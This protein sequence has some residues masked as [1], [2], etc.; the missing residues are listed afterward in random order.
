MFI[1]NNNVSVESIL[2]ALNELYSKYKYMESNFEKSKSV[3]KSKIPSVEQTLEIIKMLKQKQENDE[4]MTA[5]YSLCDTIYAK[6]KVQ[7]I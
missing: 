6:A 2:G 4:E 3:Y 5:N 1:E 7:S